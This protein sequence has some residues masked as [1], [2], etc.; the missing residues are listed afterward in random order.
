MGEC[1]DGGWACLQVRGCRGNS[2]STR[3]GEQ[4]RAA[5]GSLQAA[6]VS[7]GGGW[8]GRLGAPLVGAGGRAALTT[9]TLDHAQLWHSGGSFPVTVKPV[10]TRLP[11]SCHNASPAAAP[12]SEGSQA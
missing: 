5:P 6:W 7:A 4:A 9:F 3:P 11:T 8:A 10:S 1:V 2:S 12:F